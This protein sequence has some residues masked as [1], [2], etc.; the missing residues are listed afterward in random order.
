MSTPLNMKEIRKF[1]KFYVDHYAYAELG[2]F[3]IMLNACMKFYC[4]DYRDFVCSEDLAQ[5]LMKLQNLVPQANDYFNYRSPFWKNL[6]DEGFIRVINILSLKGFSWTDIETYVAVKLSPMPI[7]D[8]L[9]EGHPT[10]D[11]EDFKQWVWSTYHAIMASL[12][13]NE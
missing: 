13:A 3:P 12:G 10:E 8:L 1:Y 4:P 11:F 6:D 2:C 9:T 7:K 5:A